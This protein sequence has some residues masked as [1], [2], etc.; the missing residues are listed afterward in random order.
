[1]KLYEVFAIN[2]IGEKTIEFATTDGDEANDFFTAFEGSCGWEFDYGIDEREIDTKPRELPEVVF[3]YACEDEYGE[4]D[5]CTRGDALY[6]LRTGRKVIVEMSTRNLN[7]I[8]LPYIDGFKREWPIAMPWVPAA[9]YGF[10]AV[11]DDDLPF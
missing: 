10:Q 4:F 2:P 7:L 1:M 3:H 11:E 9:D 6:A 8:D 5:F